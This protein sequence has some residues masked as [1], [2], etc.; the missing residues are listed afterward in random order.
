M[1][2]T[3][4]KDINS[5]QLK[6]AEL[7]ATGINPKDAYIKCGYKCKNPNIGASR[8]LHNRF[9]KAHINELKA[10]STN[11]TIAT[12]EECKEILTNIVKSN[13][14]KSIV[15]KAID[16]LSKLSAWE[17]KKLDVS[18]SK[19]VEELSDEDLLGYL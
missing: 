1:G 16:Q 2:R 14:S 7:V 10:K 3:P 15:I 4:Q 18:I 5:K 19:K 8:L 11:E 9:I 13:E 17:T 12:L 6:F